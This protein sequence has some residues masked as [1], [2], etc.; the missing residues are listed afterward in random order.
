MTPVASLQVR[1]SK[2]LEAAVAALHFG[3]SEKLQSLA[4]SETP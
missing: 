4:E 2:K 3:V 1:V